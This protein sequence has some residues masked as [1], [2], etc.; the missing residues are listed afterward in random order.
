MQEMCWINFNMGCFEIDMALDN[1][2]AYNEINF[3][4][5]CFEITVRQTS[6]KG[7]IDKL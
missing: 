5:G 1:S 7:H 2:F 6:R 4:M 3:N